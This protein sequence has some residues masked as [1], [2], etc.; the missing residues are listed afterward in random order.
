MTK[1]TR[2]F[3]FAAFIILFVTISPM[4][5]MYAF[6]FKFNLSQMQLQKTGMLVLETEPTGAKIYLDGKLEINPFKFYSK[7]NRY[8]KT[9]TKIK[10]IVP[11]EHTI[12]MELDG[13][14][15]WEKRLTIRPGETVFA[16]NVVLFE[17]KLPLIL[18]NQGKDSL[19]AIQISQDKE[20]IALIN[21]NQLTI[22]NLKKG[23]ELARETLPT[24]TS[25]E[26]IWSKDNKK[27]IIDTIIFDINAEEII[28]LKDYVNGN[29]HNL[30]WENN[31]N[32]Y[33]QNNSGVHV[34]NLNNKKTERLVT[35]KIEDYLIKGNEL[36]YLATN[37]Q[38]TALYVYNL[39]EEKNIGQINLTRG[40]Y[41]FIHQE[42]KYINLYDSA[43]QKIYLLEV[44]SPWTDKYNLKEIN[45]V[46]TSV[47]SG[48]QLFYHN[49]FEIS[50]WD[51]R[52]N[53]D[54]LLTR[55]SEKI[56]EIVW[57][58]S[59]NYIIY[60][61][62]KEINT[63]ELDKREK[64]N[65]NTLTALDQIDFI[66]IDQDGNQLYFYAEIGNQTG[67]YKLEI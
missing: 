2:G 5:L 21:H 41:Q 32:L 59:N 23:K 57:H 61:T 3:L 6:G 49:D 67:L 66:A 65:T 38:K 9:P 51:S 40:A 53:G 31:N 60:S 48:D 47:W 55:L 56:N 42:N 28:N 1:K 10:N 12:R 34:F 22:L 64:H 25:Q 19:Q 50:I 44:M 46:K 16:E 11:G 43:G 58:P 33:Y 20:K 7:N 45:N 24:I 62:N 63:L 13:Y 37:S 35:A 27:I 30:K 54:T 14:W 39:N 18:S 26:I 8:T 29:P 36:F 4:M 17:K 15:E 52:D